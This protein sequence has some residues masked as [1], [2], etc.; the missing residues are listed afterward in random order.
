M[1]E[2]IFA[3]KKFDF[4]KLAAFGF[5]AEKDGMYVYAANISGGQFWLKIMVDDSG[6]VASRVFDNDTGDEYVLYRAE[7]A[8]GAFVGEIRQECA[9]VLQKIAETC[10]DESIFKNDETLAVIAY[11]REKYGDEL[12]FL[13]QKFPDNAVFRRQDNRKWYAAILTVSAKKLAPEQDM[14]VEVIDLRGLPDEIAAL[15]DGKKYFPGYHMNKTH[16]YTICLNGS[17]ALDE[18]CR[19]VDES[20]VLA[21][22]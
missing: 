11:V 2:E 15:T 18:I 3:H 4:G 9:K 14:P 16:W 20:Y 22:K 6:K 19:R 13:W 8:V 10:C 12:E 17:V 21:K 5:K 1:F 7:N